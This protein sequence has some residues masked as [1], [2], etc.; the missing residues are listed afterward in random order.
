MFFF[1]DA[2][3]R[4]LRW[5][6]LRMVFRWCPRRFGVRGVV[7]VVFFGGGTLVLVFLCV[8]R[9]VFW[10]WCCF[11]RWCFHVCVSFRV[12]VISLSCVFWRSR[13]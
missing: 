11:W 3:M 5:C 7:T 1:G 13:F 8:G 10:G 9:G 12:L 4:V 2:L 6:F